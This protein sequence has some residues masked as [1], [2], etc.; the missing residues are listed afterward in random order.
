MLRSDVNRSKSVWV[1][2]PVRFWKPIGALFYKLE[3]SSTL[4]KYNSGLGC[5][6]SEILIYKMAERR[7]ISKCHKQPR[8][9]FRSKVD[10]IFNLPSPFFLNYG[11]GDVQSQNEAKDFPLQQVLFWNNEYDWL[12]QVWEFQANYFYYKEQIDILLSFSAISKYSNCKEATW[13]KY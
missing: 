8:F 9:T 13:Y 5:W 6:V 1:I 11:I 10:E 4:Q 2:L 7:S 12:Y 3:N